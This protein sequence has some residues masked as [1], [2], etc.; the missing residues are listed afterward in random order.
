MTC[1]VWT[2]VRV[3]HFQSAEM[4]EE[5]SVSRSQP[6]DGELCCSD[7]LVDVILFCSSV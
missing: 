5:L 1:A 4:G 2:Y 7:Q 3:G 6:R